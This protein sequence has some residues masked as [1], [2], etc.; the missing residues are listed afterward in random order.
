MLRA[1]PLVVTAVLAQGEAPSFIPPGQEPLLSEMLG[2]GVELPGACAW[3]G[4]TVEETRVVSW[5][6]CAGTRVELELRHVS[7]ATGSVAQT[8]KFAIRARANP[9]LPPGLADAIGARV[10]AREAAFVWKG[11]DGPVPAVVLALPREQQRSLAQWLVVSL[12]AVAFIAVALWWLARRWSRAAP[13]ARTSPVW[14]LLVSLGFAAACFGTLRFFGGALWAS[15]QRDPVLPLWAA[16]CLMLL[17]AALALGAASLLAILPSQFPRWA[18][19]LAGPAVFIAVGYPVSLSREF[20]P[21]FGT[22]APGRPNAVD[23]ER[24]RDRPPVTYRTGPLGFR[25]P[26]WSP[27]K[28]AGT[29]RIGLIGDSYV[30]GIGVEEGDTLSAALKAEL[31]RRSPERAV[32]VINLGIP[33]TN[34]SSYVELADAAS[35]LELDAMIFCLTLP[36]DLS[37]WDQQQARREAGRLGAYSLARFVLGEAA[38][39]LWDLSSL[40]RTTTTAG[41]AHLDHELSRLAAL[42]SPHPPALVFYS[43]R[44]LPSPVATRLAATPGAHVIPEAESFPEDFLPNDGHPTPEGNRRSARRLADGLTFMDA[45]P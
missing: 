25:Q 42:R 12:A 44:D 23:T 45:Q 14:V 41:L 40:E 3:A 13:G 27:S 22:L 28:P 24:R 6:T 7:E 30:F 10:R 43:F 17:C 8:S 5:Y 15:L 1:F 19:L 35:A 2:K 36:N 4:A 26:G 11:A 21:T 9:P 18:R 29:R 32:E 33:G 38:D 20:A 31:A 37:R 16:T 39:V 34:L